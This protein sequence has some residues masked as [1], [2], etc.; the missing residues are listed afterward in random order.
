MLSHAAKDAA[1]QFVLGKMQGYFSNINGRL[2]CYNTGREDTGARLNRS[3]SHVR[4]RCRRRVWQEVVDYGNYRKDECK[5]IFDF[6]PSIS[7]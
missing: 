3:S 5:A 4:Q 2:K 7:H 1:K 6:S